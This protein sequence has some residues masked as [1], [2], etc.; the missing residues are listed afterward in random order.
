[1]LAE[2]MKYIENV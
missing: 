1:M 2:I